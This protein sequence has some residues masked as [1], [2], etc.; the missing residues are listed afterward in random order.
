[1]LVEELFASEED[2]GEVRD[3]MEK[4]IAFIIRD[5]DFSLYQN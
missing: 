2:S 1:M 5:I 3:R 4:L